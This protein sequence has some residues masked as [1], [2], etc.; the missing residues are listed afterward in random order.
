MKWNMKTW[1]KVYKLYKSW[2]VKI[3]F[4]GVLWLPWRII[5]NVFVHF[6]FAVALQGSIP[7]Q[8]LDSKTKRS[9]PLA[10]VLA[11]LLGHLTLKKIMPPKKWTF[12]SDV[13]IFIDLSVD[14]GKGKAMFLQHLSILQ[15]LRWWDK[16]EDVCSFYPA[17]YCQPKHSK[18]SSDS[19]RHMFSLFDLPKE[20]ESPPRLPEKVG[21]AIC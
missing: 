4:D 18:T 13:L 14:D 20:I 17:F 15:I 6:Y 1:W 12:I 19:L 11:P 8:F 9:I 7:F 16:Y 3:Q 5:S 10:Q 21:T 2:K